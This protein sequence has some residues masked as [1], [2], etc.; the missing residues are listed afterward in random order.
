MKNLDQVQEENEAAAAAAKQR[1]QAKEETRQTLNAAANGDH[2]ADDFE[3]VAADEG[4]MFTQG[5]LNKIL[6]ERLRKEREKYSGK[7]TELAAKLSGIEAELTARER[8]LERGTLKHEAKKALESYGMI[9]DNTILE[10]VLGVDVEETLDKID[11]LAKMVGKTPG[12]GK[13]R[14]IEPDRTREAF[15]LSEL[16]ERSVTPEMTKSLNPYERRVTPEMIKSLNPFY[17]RSD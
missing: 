8:A 14:Y 9:T 11:Q 4:R 10:T 7:T 16:S 3:P 5:E 13:S 6:S 17:T 12:G 15:G 1:E 2:L